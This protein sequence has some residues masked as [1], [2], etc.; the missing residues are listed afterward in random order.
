MRIGTG[1]GIVAGLVV[2]AMVKQPERV[3][4]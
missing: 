1:T 3:T 4:A 2:A